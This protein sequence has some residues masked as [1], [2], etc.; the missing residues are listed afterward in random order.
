[1]F[2]VCPACGSKQTVPP[3]DSRGMLERYA[4]ANKLR[5]AAEFDR[6][7]E[8][9]ESILAYAPR[10]A[11]AWWG[12]CLCR[13]GIDY[14]TDP[15]SFEKKPTCHRTLTASIF[16]DEDY[17]QCIR[18]AD[19][20]AARMYAEEAAEIDRVQKGILAIARKEQPYDVF[21][22][23]KENDDETGERTR[24][25]VLAQ[26]LYFAL[27]RE[28]YRVF[29]AR[30]TLEKKL[31]ELYEPL[32]YA[33]LTSAKVML[34]IGTKRKSAAGRLNGS[35]AGTRTGGQTLAGSRHRSARER[36]SSGKSE[37]SGMP[38]C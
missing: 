33:A 2:C 7:A 32:I 5:R 14:V 16:E 27:T 1:M 10:D 20:V 36:T 13:Y 30:V 24:D 28:G 29:F 19:S 34:V 11:E 15:V 22:C 21:I 23:Y 18:C 9:Y 6:A 38:C 12:K 17:R 4:Q 25:S 8:V 3:T 26:E 31:G 35:G 37:T